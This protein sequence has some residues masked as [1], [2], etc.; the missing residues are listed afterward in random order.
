MESKTPLLTRDEER[1]VE[2][3]W[4]KI[5]VEEEKIQNE[6]GWLRWWKQEVW[7]Q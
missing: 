3:Y 6:R 4:M 2:L 1:I 5:V 7:Y